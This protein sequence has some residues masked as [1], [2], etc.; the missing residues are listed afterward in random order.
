MRDNKAEE[1]PV[2]SY[3]GSR[4]LFFRL[5]DKEKRQ[6][7]LSLSLAWFQH[8]ERKENVA[9]DV[10]QK[11]RSGSILSCQLNNGGPAGLSSTTHLISRAKAVQTKLGL[12]PLNI[13][14]LLPWAV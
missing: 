14:M 11:V 5:T 4:S 9:Y 10:P 3:F 8:A 12:L 7:V 1:L 13:L 2:E 6:G